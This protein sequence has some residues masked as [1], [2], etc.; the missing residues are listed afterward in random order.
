M[1][2]FPKILIFILFI[3]AMVTFVI[4]LKNTASGREYQGVIDDLKQT[5]TNQGETSDSLR[6]TLEKADAAISELYAS[7]KSLQEQLADMTSQKEDLESQLTEAQNNI[8]ELESNLEEANANIEDLTAKNNE[9]QGTIAQLNEQVTSLET[10]LASSKASCEELSQ[11]VADLNTSLQIL[12][13]LPDEPVTVALLTD[14]LN[15]YK[16]NYANEQATTADLRK[17]LNKMTTGYVAENG[18]VTSAQALGITALMF[19]GLVLPMEGNTYNVMRDDATIGNLTID[20]VFH[21]ILICRRKERG[22]T[23][24][25]ADGDKIK[26]VKE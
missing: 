21:T 7:E 18:T 24:D 1:R 19:D 12:P 26:L 5:L 3:L 13:N 9:A 17:K 14:E 4:S 11:K 16:K 22:E 15:T 8:A 23:G 10:D 6:K 25:V 2:A 20:D